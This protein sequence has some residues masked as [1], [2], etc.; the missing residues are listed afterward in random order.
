[1]QSTPTQ[2]AAYIARWAETMTKWHIRRVKTCPRWQFVS[3]RG[4]Y[5][6]ESVGIIDILAIRKDHSKAS[7]GLKRG[8]CLQII[9]IQIKGG[10][11]ANPS[12]QDADRLRLVRRRYHADEAVLA[13]W[14]R[15]RAVGFY[16]LK[17]RD[18]DGKDWEQI[19]K[20][21]EVFG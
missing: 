12:S 17:R 3:F 18:P 1:M 8:D 16:R 9:L 11:A 21:V 2:K 14:K 15:G 10:S 19:T 6:G 4:P 13:T 7:N 5:G 20:L